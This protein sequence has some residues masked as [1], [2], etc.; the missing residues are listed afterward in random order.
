MSKTSSGQLC[1]KIL[2]REF[3][4]ELIDTEGSHVKLR[5]RRGS[6]TDTTVVPLHRE[7][8]TGT[9]RG[10]LKLAKVDWEEFR[11]FL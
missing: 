8:S 4:F 2:C 1:V 10:V 6:M 7:L 9:L 3:G 11:R 5:R